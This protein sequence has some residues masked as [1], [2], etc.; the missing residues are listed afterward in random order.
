MKRLLL[1]LLV[2]GWVLY[3]TSTLVYFFS[4]ENHITDLAAK[5]FVQQSVNHDLVIAN[6]PCD[7]RRAAF[8]RI[9]AAANRHFTHLIIGS[10]RVMQMGK[11]TGFKNSLNLGVSGASFE[12]IEIIYNLVAE[13]NITFDTLHVDFNP[14]YSHE[15]DEAKFKTFDPQYNLQEGL[16]TIGLFK[17]HRPEILSILPALC[18]QNIKDSPKNTPGHI[19]FSDGSIKQK[20]TPPEK[21]LKNVNNTV[22]NLYHKIRTHSSIQIHHLKKVFHF[23]DQCSQRKTTIVYLSPFHPSLF[24]T[25][26]HDDRILNIKRSEQLLKQY[27]SHLKIVGSFE[28]TQIDHLFDSTCF[29][30]AMHID[31]QAIQK[32]FSSA[33]TYHE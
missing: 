9:K 5:R 16:K 6:A 15:D 8:Q 31:E 12:D 24:R 28:S 11:F 25:Y 18:Y 1:T 7:E 23:Y 33:S 13:N 3:G 32:Y 2:F 10:S 4:K 29:I 19:I 17:F 14:W 30:D 21:R 27:C 22:T 26:P 20:A